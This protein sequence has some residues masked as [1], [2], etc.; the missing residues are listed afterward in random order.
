MLELLYCEQLRRGV[1]RRLHLRGRRGTDMLPGQHVHQ[2]GGAAGLARGPAVCRQLPSAVAVA[3]REPVDKAWTRGQGRL[4]VRVASRSVRS[5]GRAPEWPRRARRLAAG[6]H[7]EGRGAR[8]KP[9]PRCRTTARP[10]GTSRGA[11]VT[12]TSRTLAGATSSRGRWERGTSGSPRSWSGRST[13][14]STPRRSSSRTVGRMPPASMPG[15]SS[16]TTWTPCDRSSSASMDRKDEYALALAY[17]VGRTMSSAEA[18]AA[19]A[20]VG[21][22]EERM[23]AMRLATD[24]G[25]A[26]GRGTRARRAGKPGRGGPCQGREQG[27]A[28]SCWSLGS[29][30]RASRWTPRAPATGS[31]GPASGDGTEAGVTPRSAQTTS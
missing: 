17:L 21:A 4:H 24:G 23:A 25:S 7:H 3:D 22:G 2:S 13:A 29:T 11:T 12:W 14:L 19:A 18:A 16:R 27:H 26:G 15:S 30:R 28:A 1:P 9:Y 5:A 31:P 8:L 20:K 10:A 6:G